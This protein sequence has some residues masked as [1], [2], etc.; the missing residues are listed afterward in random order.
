MSALGQTGARHQVFPGDRGATT[1]AASRGLQRPARV[2]VRGRS[3]QV[4]THGDDLRN[5]RSSRPLHRVVTWG[6]LLVAS[7][8]AQ[9]G[10][11]NHRVLPARSEDGQRWTVQPEILAERASVPGARLGGPGG[12]GPAG[13]P[14]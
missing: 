8:R 13:N 10:P 7:L 4:Q 1:V 2:L 9:D 5:S 11:W 14:R 6:L 3:V 12:S